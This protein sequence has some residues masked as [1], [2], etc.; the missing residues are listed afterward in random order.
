MSKDKPASPISS[1]D[2]Q[3]RTA[4]GEWKSMGAVTHTA[5]ARRYIESLDLEQGMYIVQ[6]RCSSG[7][8]VFGHEVYISKEL[9]VVPIRRRIK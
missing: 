2:R 6:T 1:M 4:S 8:S 9:R 5:A 3:A 7:E